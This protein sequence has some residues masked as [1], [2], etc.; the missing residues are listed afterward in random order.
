MKIGQGDHVVVIGAGVIGVMCAWNLSLAGFQVTI[1]DRDKFGAACS[2]GNCGYVCPS[3]VLPLGQ[4]G[5][6][7]KTLKGMLKTNS[8][9]AIRPRLETSFFSWFWNFARRCNHRDMMSA[10]V[11]RHE[12]LQSSK[13]LYQ[14][15][16]A[17][18]KIDCQWQEVG[19][20]FVFDDERSFS[21]FGNC[22]LYT[23]PSPRDKRQSRMPSSA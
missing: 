13:R 1:V 11:G 9:F 23:S 21:Q 7:T 12:I 4:P 18:Q 17:D 22:L 15:L 6:I 19:L 10:A 5:A 8:P 20:L 16:I 3:H 14:E 2:H